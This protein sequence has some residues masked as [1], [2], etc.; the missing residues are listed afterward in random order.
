MKINFKVAVLIIILLILTWLGNIYVF[1]KNALVRPL[2]IKTYSDL[3]IS[4]TSRMEFYYITNVYDQDNICTASFPELKTEPVYVDVA[5]VKTINNS[6]YKINKI[7]IN[8]GN[9]FLSEGKR[10]VNS[11]GK[12][13]ITLKKVL[14][15][16]LS[17][18]K[19][20][21]DLGNISLSKWQSDEDNSIQKTSSSSTNGVAGSSTA[22]ANT[23][24]IIDMV[25]SSF[26]NV[27]IELYDIDI[28][29]IPLENFPHILELKAGEQIKVA[30]KLKDKAPM[31]LKIK[32]SNIRSSI[33]LTGT[34]KE[35][36]SVRMASFIDTNPFWYLTGSDVRDLAKEGI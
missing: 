6:N 33:T 30:Y 20:K 15:S 22:F 31:D 25:K 35:G 27:L 5:Q 34:N 7:V 28:N 2:L 4:E 3:F 17:N 36:K 29:G 12:K 1:N 18:K 32:Y 11:S 23:D 16:T 8:M 26:K 14:F 10:F 19:F 9:I 21:F 13:D 24:I